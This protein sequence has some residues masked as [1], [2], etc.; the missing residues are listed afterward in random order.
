MKQWSALLGQELRSWPGVTSR[1]MFSMMAFYRKKIIF[2]LLP[3]TRAL[4]T[5]NSIAFKLY[6]E[7]PKTSKLLRADSRV[8]VAADKDTWIGFEVTAAGDLQDALKWLDLAYRGSVNI[9][10]KS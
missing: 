3:R 6:G 8:R 9:K 2:A 7:S 10:L 5:A 4:E 1:P